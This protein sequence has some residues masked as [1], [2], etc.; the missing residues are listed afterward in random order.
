MTSK[1]NFTSPAS[2]TTTLANHVLRPLLQRTITPFPLYLP[3]PFAFNMTADT[4]LVAMDLFPEYYKDL[5]FNYTAMWAYINRILFFKNSIEI[6]K[7][8]KEISKFHPIS[9]PKFVVYTL[10]HKILSWRVNIRDSMVEKKSDKLP[11]NIN[12]FVQYMAGKY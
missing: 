12:D 10:I 1:I 11:S 3:C 5:E 7:N 8:S 2:G 9:I 4:V 6:L